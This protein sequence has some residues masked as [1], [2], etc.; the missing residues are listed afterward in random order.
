[1]ICFV[2]HQLL[3]GREEQEEEEEKHASPS[4][5]A[6]CAVGDKIWNIFFSSS[7]Y[8]SFE[9]NCLHS[10]FILVLFVFPYEIFLLK[11]ELTR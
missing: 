2:W 1:M 9:R 10:I 7:V 5:V 6:P 11:K 8:F 4:M 3:F